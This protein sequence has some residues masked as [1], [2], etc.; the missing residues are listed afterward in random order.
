MTGLSHECKININL[1]V[2][3]GSKYKIIYSIVCIYFL[4]AIN[5]TDSFWKN[6]LPISNKFLITTQY[7]SCLLNNEQTIFYD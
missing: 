5:F 4:V 6:V 3:N 2:G 7:S 1:F